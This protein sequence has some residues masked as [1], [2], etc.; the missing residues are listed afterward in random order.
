MGMRITTSMMMNTYRY[1]LQGSTSNLSDAR[2]KVLSQRKFDS[3]AEDPAAATQAWRIRRA[4]SSNFDYQDNN[5]DTYSRFNIASTTMGVVSNKLTDASG[6][7]STIRG[8]NGAIGAGRQPLGK[9]LLETAE[10][11]VQAMNSAKYG[12]HFVFAGDDEMNTPFTWDGDTLLYRGVNVGAGGEKK[13]SEEPDWGTID[14]ATN[15]PSNMPSTGKTEWEK[16]WINYYRDDA[17]IK[18]GETVDNPAPKPSATDDPF[19][20]DIADGKVDQFGIPD[21]YSDIMKNGSDMEKLWATYYKDQGDVQKLKRMSEEE[22][23]VDLGMGLEED[24]SGLVMGTAFNRSLPGINMLGGYGVD[25]DGDPKNAVLIMKRLGE[26]FYNSDPDSGEWPTEENATGVQ[27][28]AYRLLNKLNASHHKIVENYADLE[29][30]AQFLQQNQTRLETQGDYLQEE[31]L[32]LEQVD[33]ADAITE[34]SW[35]YYC[36]SA[37]LKIGT[38]LLSQSLLDYMG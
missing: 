19:A 26:I 24:E 32:N 25:E 9:V 7:V 27:A 4:M 1:N 33:L 18:N 28:E 22:Q 37:A 11:V 35:D 15:L 16:A 2:N 8:L 14:P 20:K 29:A 3:Y 34:F 5:S 31:R 6:R 30:R 13:P 21:S 10:T 38:Q 36:Y 17:R 23:N 12:D